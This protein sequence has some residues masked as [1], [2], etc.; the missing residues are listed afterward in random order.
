MVQTHSKIGQ[1]ISNDSHTLQKEISND[2]HTL[3][4][5]W[6]SF[7]TPHQMMSQTETVRQCHKNF[8]LLSKFIACLCQAS[9]FLMLKY[10][11]EYTVS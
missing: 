1:E 4:K 8:T 9:S 10:D 11:L 3:Q 5:L 7:Q 2:Y 6:L